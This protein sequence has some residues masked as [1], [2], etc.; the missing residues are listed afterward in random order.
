MR[1]PTRSSQHN[2]SRGEMNRT[3]MSSAASYGGA[4]KV[5]PA[6]ASSHTAAAAAVRLDPYWQTA[7]F[8][9][10]N[11]WK[12]SSFCRKEG[13]SGQAPTKLHALSSGQR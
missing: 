4:A 9:P 13:R 1:L 3:P 7:L 12:A 11:S 5:Y 6:I 10:E 2:Q 8:P